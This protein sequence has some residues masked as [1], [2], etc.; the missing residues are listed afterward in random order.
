MSQAHEVQQS[1]EEV[2]SLLAHLETA[3][4]GEED[5]G[6]VQR[7]LRSYARLLG[8]LFEAQMTLKRLQT[9][10]FGT[11]RR[12]RTVPA[13]GAFTI[14]GGL[15]FFKILT[16]ERHIVRL[17]P[18]S[19][20][21]IRCMPRTP[22]NTRPQESG[23]ACLRRRTSPAWR[24]GVARPP[25]RGAH[26]CH[27]PWPRQRRSAPRCWLHEASGTCRSVARIRSRKATAAAGNRTPCRQ[28]RASSRSTCRSETGS[29]RRKP[30]CT[31]R[32]M[33]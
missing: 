30:C 28:I 2:R 20:G 19:G 31:S 25:S 10:L 27:R 23:L 1:L 4:W 9:L 5:W 18:K 6:I 7:V 29:A 17:Y 24:E 22:R 8:M 15:A 11:R 16:G 12:R 14:F 32:V 26:M 33:A 13:A 21:K 3:S